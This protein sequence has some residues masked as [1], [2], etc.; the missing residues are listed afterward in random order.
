MDLEARL[1]T[2][3]AAPAAADANRVLAA[4]EEHAG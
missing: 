1:D 3:T 4:H 2:S